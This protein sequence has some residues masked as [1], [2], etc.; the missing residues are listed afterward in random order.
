MPHTGRDAR[1]TSATVDVPKKAKAFGGK[2][3]RKP[4]LKGAQASTRARRARRQSGS[5]NL[6]DAV[7]QGG[8]NEGCGIPKGPQD[9][10]H[11][12]YGTFWKVANS[13]AEVKYEGASRVENTRRT[14]IFSFRKALSGASRR[15]NFESAP[16]KCI[17]GATPNTAENRA[18]SLFPSVNEIGEAK[19][20]VK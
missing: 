1:V 13:I 6:A 16:F 17:E 5:Q 12:A 3:R 8:G 11:P 20:R 7:H 10:T 4:N 2:I 14:F 18:L 19:E 15:Q 9:V